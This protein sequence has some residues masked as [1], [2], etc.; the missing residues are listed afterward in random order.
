VQLQLYALAASER[1]GLPVAGGLYRSLSASVDRGFVA[2]TVAGAFKPNDIVEP[3]A[4]DALL[5]Q[6]VD[7]A[8][9]AYEGMKAG[10]IAPAPEK[11][12]C[13]YC[14]ALAFCPEGAQS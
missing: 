2:K 10:E 12:R 14:A 7:A 11:G 1:L 6:A 5:A 9:V 3:S 8:R 13:Q 4:I